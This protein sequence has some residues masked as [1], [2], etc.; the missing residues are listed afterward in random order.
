MIS[1]LVVGL[2]IAL[3]IFLDMLFLKKKEVL[4]NQVY[5][6]K[7]EV[8][9]YKIPTYLKN[10]MY[11]F[12]GFPLIVIIC[13]FAVII[14]GSQNSFVN[15]MK[16]LILFI[17][18]IAYG[19]INLVFMLKYNKEALVKGEHVFILKCRYQD[20]DLSMACSEKVFN[21]VIVGANLPEVHKHTGRFIH[22]YYFIS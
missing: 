16:M 2:L 10:T 20:Q 21:K 18:L 3:V 1:L 6:V 17:P 9:L 5:L 8:Q 13:T 4:K 11:V 14:D 19:I 22:D 7:K 15:A 12:S